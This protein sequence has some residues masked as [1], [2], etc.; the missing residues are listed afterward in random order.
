MN[1]TLIQRSKSTSYGQLTLFCKSALRAQADWLLEVLAPIVEKQPATNSELRLQFWWTVFTIQRRGGELV[2]QEPDYS[3]NPFQHLTTDLSFTLALAAQ[4]RD[5]LEQAGAQPSPPMFHQ[6]V[7]LGKGVLSTQ[8]LYLER[9]APE[10]PE[11]SGWFIGS[12]EEDSDNDQDYEA[13]Y[14]FEVARERP[15]VIPLLALP[16]GYS[17][18]LV[19]DRIH[20]VVDPAER[21]VLSGG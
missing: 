10:V 8:K 5:L 2:I 6:R 4:Q 18:L 15:G 11:D 3:K 20:W 17:A 7:V 13:R 19:G 9:S 12:G 1:S 14:V 21:I 16:D